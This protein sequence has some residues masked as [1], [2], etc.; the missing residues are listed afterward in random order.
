MVRTP[1]FDLPFAQESGQKQRETINDLLKDFDALI[2][3]LVLDKDL[4]SPP[5][6]PT[7]GDAYIV[8]GGATGD[9]SGYDNN[10]AVWYFSKWFFQP[11]WS[12][13]TAWVSDESVE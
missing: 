4:T 7:T 3:P 11:P 9:W 1:R 13:F 10:I 2:H 8:G 6:S 5:A 12:G